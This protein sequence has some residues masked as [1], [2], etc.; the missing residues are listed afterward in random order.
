L[1]QAEGKPIIQHVY[2]NASQ[3]KIL[4]ELIIGT[5]DKRIYETAEKFNAQVVYTSK[6]HKSGTD[7]VAEVASRLNYDIIVNIQG[8]EPLLKEKMIKKLVTCLKNNRSVGVCTLAKKVE[9]VRELKDPGFVRIVVDRNGDALYFTRATVPFMRDEQN[10]ENWLKY[11]TYLKHIG[12]YGFRKHSLLKFSSLPEAKLEKIEKLEQ[13][14]LLENGI[15]IRVVETR[16]GCPVSIDTSED[17][18]QFR[19]YLK[20]KNSL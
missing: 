2:E 18:E 17:L 11:F 1:K 6:M 9:N 4:D 10:E 13:L 15:K 7:R 12:I 20:S 14:R 5:D 16:C 8:D 3:F 19:N